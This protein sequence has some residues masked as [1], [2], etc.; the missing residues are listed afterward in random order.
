MKF[1]IGILS[2]LAS[3]LAPVALVVTVTAMPAFALEKDRIGPEVKKICF[4]STL[5]RWR[6]VEG[7]DGVILVDRRVNDWYRVTVNAGCTESIIRRASYL[8]IETTP[9]SSCLKYNDRITA[10]DSGGFE[11][12]C[13]IKKINKWDHTQSDLADDESDAPQD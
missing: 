2:R 9:G 1:Q 6:A 12:Q 8:R 5:D 10:V 3:I 13:H 11:Y 7:E 4:S